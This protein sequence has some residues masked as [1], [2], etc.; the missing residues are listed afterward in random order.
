MYHYIKI[1]NTPKGSEDLT[2]GARILAIRLMQK[3]ERNSEHLKK[4]GV[5]V[6]LIKK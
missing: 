3:K 6:K 4:I 1:R 5:D 2:P